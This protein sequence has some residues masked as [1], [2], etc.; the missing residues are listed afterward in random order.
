MML[1]EHLVEVEG[2]KMDHAE[3]AVV[4]LGLAND[5]CK[6]LQGYSR[7]VAPLTDITRKQNQAHVNGLQQV[8]VFWRV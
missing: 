8:G 1:Q 6:V 3:T 2:T 7:L 4:N 5:F